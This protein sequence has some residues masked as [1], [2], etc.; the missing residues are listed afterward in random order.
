MIGTKDVSKNQLVPSIHDVFF[1]HPS[2]KLKW[3][4]VAT[5]GLSIFMVFW[6]LI[7]PS[8]YLIGRW[9][10]HDRILFG[11]LKQGDTLAPPELTLKY[12]GHTAVHLTH[13]L[14]GAVWAGI[15]PF[16]IHDGFRRQN[17]KMHRIL[18]MLFFA[19][20]IL[21]A[22]GVLVILHRELLFD[23]FFPDLP[24]KP[25]EVRL[26]TDVGI[27]G[28]SFWFFCSAAVAL[29]YAK[30]KKFRLHRRFII[31]HIASG[32]WI[33]L[34]RVLLIG[35]LPI[36]IRPPISRSMQ[37][38]SFGQTAQLAIVC[39]GLLGEYAIHLLERDNAHLKQS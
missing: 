5:T 27:V 33:S 13:F 29:Y 36:F 25:K 11:S 9:E 24:E 3:L 19:A 28:M 23:N 22:V 20:S 38:E 39:C 16:Q 4:Y 18:G 2:A 6:I 32:I 10:L 21:V 37:R 14:P 30:A 35:I 15:I 1:A 26:A 12:Q 34:Q 7:F 8:S 17:P 31:R